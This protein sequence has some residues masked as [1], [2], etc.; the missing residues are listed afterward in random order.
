MAFT[1]YTVT[2]EGHDRPVGFCVYS[3]PNSG[4]AD[5]GYIMLD[6]DSGNIWTCQTPDGAEYHASRL[7]GWQDGIENPYV[8]LSF[9]ITK[10]EVSV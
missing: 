4:V 5:P 7:G 9:K 6:K 2:F 1:F 3:R 8:G 10:C